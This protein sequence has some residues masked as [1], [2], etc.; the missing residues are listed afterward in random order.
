MLL[1][2]FPFNGR[3]QQVIV[4]VSEKG[5]DKSSLI[6]AWPYKGYN[7]YLNMLSKSYKIDSLKEHVFNLNS[8]EGGIFN[9][10]MSDYSFS[11]ILFPK[12]TVRIEAKID[13]CFRYDI[14]GSNAEGHLLWLQASF[15]SYIIYPKLN[16]IF[17]AKPSL[18][19][20]YDEACRL[21]DGFD[22]KMDSL[23]KVRKVSSRFKNV[24][25]KKYKGM[26]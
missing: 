17:G 15:P 16:S 11:L 25:E 13:T 1:V 9:F 8:K 26:V 24:M 22:S 21:T 4:K 20:Q 3:S 14:K 7:T 10:E 18:Q 12:D 5:K 23:C 19:E 2:L 6:I